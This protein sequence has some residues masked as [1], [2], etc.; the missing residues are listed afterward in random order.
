[1][2][3]AFELKSDLRLTVAFTNLHCDATFLLMR[4]HYAAYTQVRSLLAD[5]RVT[6]ET[7]PEAIGWLADVGFDP[8]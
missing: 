1:M 2:F 6:L 4:V 8:R 3:K 5:K 7:A